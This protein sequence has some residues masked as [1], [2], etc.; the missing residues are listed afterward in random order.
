MEL[1]T[2]RTA[3]PSAE[4]RA[5][6]FALARVTRARHTAHLPQPQGRSR[7]R[8]TRLLFRPLTL[9]IVRRDV[10]RTRVPGRLASAMSCV[11]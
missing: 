7:P 11:V 5:L 2:L 6:R 9:V 1:V 10:Y 4:L 8:N 3:P